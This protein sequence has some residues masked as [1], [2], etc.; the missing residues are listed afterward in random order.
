MVRYLQTFGSGSDLL[1]E[2]AC[3][4]LQLEGSFMVYIHHSYSSS[5]VIDLEGNL[6]IN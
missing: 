2:E 5:L 4:T 6:V 1:V 3:T